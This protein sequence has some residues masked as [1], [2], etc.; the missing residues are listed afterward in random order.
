MMITISI[1]QLMQ[2][3]NR[4]YIHH[5][6]SENPS[7][8]HQNRTKTLLLSKHSFSFTWNF[9]ENLQST[10]FLLVYFTI[11]QLFGSLCKWYF[12]T[13]TV[14]SSSASSKFSHG[15]FRAE[16][17]QAL[18]SKTSFIIHHLGPYCTSVAAV[19]GQIITASQLFFQSS[20][21]STLPFL[22]TMICFS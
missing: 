6:H 15:K 3:L 7:N 18:L 10:R 5:L 8:F 9:S 2:T 22:K 4:V 20:K 12:S 21:N 1:N 13:V 14:I 11:F 17:F 19:W 16:Q